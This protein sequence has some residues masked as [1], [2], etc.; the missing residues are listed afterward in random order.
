MPICEHLYEAGG[1]Y[2]DRSL[3][4]F[5]GLFVMPGDMLSTQDD[6]TD[7]DFH[8]ETEAD[9][10]DGRAGIKLESVF[11]FPLQRP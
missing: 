11:R 8:I 7:G 2:G 10:G 5:A 6:L 4:L 1:F 3:S 9:W